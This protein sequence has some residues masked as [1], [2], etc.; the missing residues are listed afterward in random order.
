MGENAY[1]NDMLV[2][3]E[4]WSTVQI[5]RGRVF[6]KG[7]FLSLPT[8]SSKMVKLFSRLEKR[9]ALLIITSVA[10]KLQ[11]PIRC[12]GCSGEV[13]GLPSVVGERTPLFLCGAIRDEKAVES[14]EKVH[15]R[16]D[17]SPRGPQMCG[18]DRT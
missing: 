6:G 4:I 8:A 5:V 9:V 3:S 13:C 15:F 14:I 16:L 10:K 18:A 17:H 7:K 11:K 1:R 2:G 12:L